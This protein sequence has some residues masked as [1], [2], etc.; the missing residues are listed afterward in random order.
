MSAAIDESA[1][2]RAKRVVLEVR[3]SN[4]AAISFYFAFNFRIA[5]ERRNYYS[6]PLEDAYVMERKI[7]D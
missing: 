1:R 5:G 3:K 7:S 4:S 6:N 2:R